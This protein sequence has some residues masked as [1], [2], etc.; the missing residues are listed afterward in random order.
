M[1]VNQQFINRLHSNP[2]L[3]ENLAG[4]IM[5]LGQAYC[6]LGP[7]KFFVS[8]IP[9]RKNSVKNQ[10]SAAGSMIK[11][12]QQNSHHADELQIIKDKQKNGREIS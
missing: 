3:R 1:G 5:L 11:S 10:P 2:P 6:R 9:C 4:P 7:A 12:Q 8:I